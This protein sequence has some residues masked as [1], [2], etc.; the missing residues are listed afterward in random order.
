M[1]KVSDFKD[2]HHF[3]DGDEKVFSYRFGN[4]V[5]EEVSHAGRYRAA[6]WNTAGFTLNVLD[7]INTRLNPSCYFAPQSFD[8]EVDGR[9]LTYHWEFESF[10]SNTEVLENGTEVL[11]GV[12]TLKN[13]LL[14]V[15]AC[16][17]T[18]L[19][20]TSVMTRYI[21]LTNHT[22][23]SVNISGVS[24]MRGAMD[25]VGATH[26][27]LQSKD[28]SDL[29]S[30]GYFESSRWGEEGLF[31]WHKLPV[32]RYGFCG[33][34]NDDRFR[35]PAFMLKNNTI[36]NLF[37]C[38]LAWVGGYE[39]TFDLK[40]L[41][42]VAYLEFNIA[43]DSQHP[44]EVLN[45]GETYVSPEVH[46]TAISGS[47]DD[48]VNMMHRHTRRS[49]FTLPEQETPSLG[50][51]TSG[52]GPEREMTFEAAKHFID[53][54]A[55]L[56]AETF[57]LDAGWYLP[58]GEEIT[59]WS[60]NTGN[61]YPDRDKYGEDFKEVRDYAHSKGMIFGLWMEPES[62]GAKAEIL[63]EH[64]DWKGVNY[65]GTPS[66]MIN[67]ANPDAVRWV[68]SEISR[69]IE[70]YH[71]EFFRLDFNA[72]VY[73]WHI[74]NE[75]NGIV[76]SAEYEY[77]KNT[78][79][80]YRRLRKK[81]PNVVFENC[82]SGGSRTTLDFVKNFTH[83]WVT[84]WQREP[85]SFAITN[86]MTMVLPPE[87][88]DGLTGGM[89]SHIIGSLDFQVRRAI[90]GKPSVNTFNC[91]GSKFNP[92]QISF[93]R[94]T[95]DIYKEYVRPY[96]K[97]CLIFHHTPDCGEKFPK[98]VGILERSSQNGECGILGVF[99]FNDAKD[100]VV[101]VYPRGMDLSAEYEVTF[102]NSGATVRGS[103]YSF[104]NNGIRVSVDGSLTSELIIY[105]KLS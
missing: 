104:V 105:K 65:N 7:G 61:W 99:A 64:P 36:G 95:L 51:V 67:M 45:P 68:E 98:G 28:L 103:A 48:A 88:V 60:D 14:E 16:V 5:Y 101:T 76:H 29:Y 9:T 72:E 40:H 15:T 49:V 63:K 54:A 70:E 58:A 41:D 35:H 4:T 37:F 46:I 82:A 6:G 80:M 69:I 53:T 90:M 96:A 79:E 77:Y 92:N 71:L 1:L 81:Y 62:L 30:L 31:S 12:V 13:T 27:V 52:V 21:T 22:D 78:C 59:G 50:L 55:E 2:I 86:G 93:V 74:Q 32:A 44:L 42:N 84:D 18:I 56:G 91:I 73:D 39:I 89:N 8:I 97:D 24:P 75:K 19:D 85:R 94:H 23:K 43:I 17:H 57:G 66:R 87:K 11:H 10:E 25:Y 33:K 3:T 20:G 47:L 83:T 34:Y 100:N 102:D 38:Q 26:E